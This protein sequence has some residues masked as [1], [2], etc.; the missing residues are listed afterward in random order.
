M[1]DEE[2]REAMR[3]GEVYHNLVAD[4][5]SRINAHN[6]RAPKREPA[7]G[8]IYEGHVPKYKLVCE[9]YI[10]K[11][12]AHDWELSYGKPHCNT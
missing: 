11:Y 10:D 3:R 9:G 5:G 6:R 12:V 2:C 4:A 1:L 8:A 7:W